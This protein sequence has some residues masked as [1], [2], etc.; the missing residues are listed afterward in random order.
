MESAWLLPQG[1]SVG[2]C[3]AGIF[4]QRL[5]IALGFEVGLDT[6]GGQS[7]SY[8]ATG[9]K[10]EQGDQWEMLETSRSV[11]KSCEAH[12]PQFRGHCL[13]HV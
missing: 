5:C 3:K 7:K 1:T 9:V 2:F 12:V 11:L 10:K 6:P 4:G 13:S 8:V